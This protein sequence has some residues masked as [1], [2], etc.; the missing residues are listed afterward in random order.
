MKTVT[1]KDGTTIAYDQVGNGPTVILVGGALQHRAFDAETPK[2]AALLA[3]HFTVFH[4]D[5]RGRGDSGD[6]LPYTVEHEIED[7][8]AL[9]DAGGGS[10][11]VYGISSGAALSMEAAIKLG[12]KIKKLVMYEVPYDARGVQQEWVSYTKQLKELLAADRHGDAVQLFLKLL[13][14]PADELQGMSLSPV[15]PLFEA[16]APTLAY[17]AAI[18][19]A[20]A[21][22]PVETAMQ[23]TI[24]TLLMAGGADSPYKNAMHETVMSLAQVIPHSQSRTLEGQN[25][26]VSPDALAPILIEFFTEN[27]NGAVPVSNKITAEKSL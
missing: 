10:A 5:R 4:Y 16:V 23:V 25:H 8:E 18:L 3:P 15:W 26:F 27:E 19:G 22:V 2:L 24:P 12:D 21:D 7:I 17:D 20:D 14:T 1:S 6:T 9:V 13:G 11:F